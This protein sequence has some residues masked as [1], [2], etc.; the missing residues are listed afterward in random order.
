MVDGKVGVWRMVRGTWFQGVLLDPVLDSSPV[1][2]LRLL[3]DGTVV[4][5]KV[6]CDKVGM[7]LLTT[8][9]FVA[10]C[11]KLATVLW[12]ITTHT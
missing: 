9:P 12:G 2:S 3:K 4:P 10:P 1:S 7:I 11:S 5:D 6:V 8:L